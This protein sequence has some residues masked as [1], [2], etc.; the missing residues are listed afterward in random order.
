M[1]AKVMDHDQAIRNLTAE[2]YLLGE[3]SQDDRDAYE[4]HLFSC[5]ACF[6]QIK[7]GTEFVGQLRRIGAEEAETAHA[8]PGFLGSLMSG[9]RQPVSAVAFALLFCAVGLNVYQNRL[10]T[11][12]HHPQ[13]VPTFFL[14]DGAKGEG[15]QVVTVPRNSR[16][17]LKLQLQLLHKGDY[18]RYEGQLQTEAGKLKSPFPVSLEQASDTINLVL[19]SSII[20]NGAY[21]IVI[22]GV[23]PDGKMSEVT[24]YRFNFHL[25]E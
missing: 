10:I 19:D 12:L 7:A 15:I 5:P 4:E 18:T 20:D 8:Q 17:D 22:Q 16:F 14:S 9:L 6:E 3:L 21:Q 23:A 1:N 24:R 25:Q 11:G 2:R 13:V